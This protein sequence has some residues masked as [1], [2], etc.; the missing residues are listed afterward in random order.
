M[1]WKEPRSCRYEDMLYEDRRMLKWQGM[2][3][4]DHNE[5]MYDD[6]LAERTERDPIYIDEEENERWD[7]LISES[8]FSGKYLKI[9]SA[10]PGE[11]EKTRF[12]IIKKVKKNMM[13]LSDNGYDSIIEKWEI[14]S[15]NEW[16]KK[17]DPE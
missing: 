13:I 15:I 10:R 11:E 2:L 9:V 3:L 8:L 14:R 5:R 6:V 17:N 16:D 4:S 7:H 1:E 12:G